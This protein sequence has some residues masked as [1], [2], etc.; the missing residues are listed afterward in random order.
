MKKLR[1]KFLPFNYVRTLYYHFPN[2]QQ[3]LSKN[4]LQQGNRSV[5]EYIKEFYPL[6]ARNELLKHE[7]Q[8]ERFVWGLRESLQ[9]AL[10]LHVFW[11]VS[12]AHQH[13][14]IIEKQQNR[15]S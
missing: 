6:M 1:K 5:D 15:T 7:E 13:A 14:L 12:E 11:Y 10:N 2:L 3:D 8:V 4:N 9:D